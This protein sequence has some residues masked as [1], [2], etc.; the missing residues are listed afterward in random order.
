M[1]RSGW[2]GSKA[3]SVSTDVRA[4][5]REVAD[6][7]FDA[8]TGRSEGG[9]R[10]AQDGSVHIPDALA[11]PFLEDNIELIGRRFV[12]TIGG[13]PRA[14]AE[15]RHAG[16]GAGADK[17]SATAMRNCARRP[18]TKPSDSRSRAPSGATSPILKPR[19]I[20]SAARGS[21]APSSA[22]MR[23]SFARL[24]TSTRS[25]RRARWGCRRCP[26]RS[27]R[28]WC[29]GFPLTCRRWTGSRRI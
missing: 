3:T 11:A 8:L 10:P 17:L 6:D 19:A 22:T 9:P 12:R 27:A 2:R 23:G 15:V 5:A 7:L 14:C 25:A 16:H 21:T 13:R 4:K 20:A 24:S 1:S 26:T 28:R 29:R 18:R